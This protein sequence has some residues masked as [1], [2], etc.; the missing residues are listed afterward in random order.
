[1][2]VFFRQ[3]S[4]LPKVSVLLPLFNAERYL[5]EAVESILAQS[6]RD[7]ELLVHDDGST[8][9]SLRILRDFS[10]SDPRVIVSSSPNQG[11]TPTLNFL[12]RKA[13]APY[14]ARMDA[15]DVAF[16]QRFERQVGYLDSHPDCVLVGGRIVLID[17]EGRKLKVFQLPTSHAEIDAENLRGRMAIA[18]PVVM[19]R[20]T[21]IKKV[22]GYREGFTHAEDIDLWLRLAEVGRLANLDEVLLY[23]R[24]HFQSVGMTKRRD[25]IGAHISA[26]SDAFVRRSL[27]GEPEISLPLVIVDEG[28]VSSW[29]RW[30]WWALQG[31]NVAVARYYAVRALRSSPFEIEN[32]R[33]LACALRGH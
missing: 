22:G 24:Q 27:T 3:G 9:G 33:L 7:F 26:V 5:A 30:G 25:Q 8:D 19:M 12:L 13:Q 11:I 4:S 31:G 32:W 20:A 1:L 10:R 15:D 23:Y 18:H 17:P 6:F 29:R 16:P 21:A 2:S 14:I 28:T